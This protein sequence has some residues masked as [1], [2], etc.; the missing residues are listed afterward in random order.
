MAEI[1]VQRTSAEGSSLG[2]RVTVREGGSSTEH[3]VTLQ[4]ADLDRLG[5]GR[6]PE[7]FV[8]ACFDFLLER[9][10]KE[11]ILRSFDIG[12]IGRYFPEF[13]ET[14]RHP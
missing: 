1:A 4:T 5:G 12:V 9:E 2:F 6:N 11:S 13:E 3:D 7:D 8:H 14:I 10:P